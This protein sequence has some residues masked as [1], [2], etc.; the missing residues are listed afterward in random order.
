MGNKTST[1]HKTP[2]AAKPLL[3]EGLSCPEC[4]EVMDKVDTTFAN[5]K[6]NRAEVGQHTGDIYFCEHCEQHYIDNLLTG[7]VEAWSY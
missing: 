2:N 5:V 6:T 4:S 1:N 7:D 3:C